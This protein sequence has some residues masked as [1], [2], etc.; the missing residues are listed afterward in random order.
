M[1]GPSDATGLSMDLETFMQTYMNQVAKKSDSLYRWYK[2][3]CSIENTNEFLKQHTHHQ[4]MFLTS[5]SSNLSLHFTL[6]SNHSRGEQSYKRDNKS[7]W[8]F[9]LAIAIIERLVMVI[10]VEL[11][12][13]SNCAL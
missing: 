3:N 9:N 2:Q 12:T 13:G 6:Y 8:R 11:S 7:G 1:L 4:K 5:S 10:Q